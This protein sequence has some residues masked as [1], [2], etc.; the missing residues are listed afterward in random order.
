MFLPKWPIV[1]VGL[2]G[3]LPAGAAQLPPATIAFPGLFAPELDPADRVLYGQQ[4]AATLEGQGFTV[5]DAEA[6]SAR[7]IEVSPHGCYSPLPPLCGAGPGVDQVLIGS[8]VPAEEEGALRVTIELVDG[9]DRRNLWAGGFQAENAGELTAGLQSIGTEHIPAA[10]R[11]ARLIDD[12][13]RF[14]GLTQQGWGGALSVSGILMVTGSG[15]LLSEAAKLE[16]RLA[17]HG[18]RHTLGLPTR[19][20]MRMRDHYEAELTASIVLGAAGLTTAVVGLLLLKDAPQKPIAI[21][22]VP[23]HQSGM[24]VFSG[25]F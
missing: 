23:S 16:R 21:Q 11:R 7:D 8:I 6:L 17:N 18:A 22:F 3:A 12:R 19:D 4:L 24:L 1:L 5:L 9:Q 14:I 20:A 15:V 10:S 13:P 25:G 2:I